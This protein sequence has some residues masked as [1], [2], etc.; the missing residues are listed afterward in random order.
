MAL[1]KASTKISDKTTWTHNIVIKMLHHR[2]KY[3]SA[4]HELADV[5]AIQ[6]Q[7]TLHMKGFQDPL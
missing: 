1:Y 6:T 7:S 5:A 2:H 4:V 3:K